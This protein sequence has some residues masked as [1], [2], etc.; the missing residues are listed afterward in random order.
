MQ[1]A[2]VANRT[3]NISLPLA[4]SGKRYYNEFVEYD[5]ISEEMMKYIAH[6]AEDGRGQSVEA[7]LLGTAKLAKQFAESFGAGSDAAF[8]G[9]LHDIGKCTA[10]FQA[11]CMAARGSI[12]LPP[13]RRLPF[14]RETFLPLLRSQDI[15]VG[16]PMAEITG[17]N[18]R[19]QL[20]AGVCGEM[21]HLTHPSSANCHRLPRNR[22]RG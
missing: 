10:G 5:K 17:T 3:E 21:A 20:F 2:Q 16:F 7:H 6:I 22:R 18:R 11:G 1:N 8:A 9:L 13:G 12:M 19:K 14:K 4:I 15:M